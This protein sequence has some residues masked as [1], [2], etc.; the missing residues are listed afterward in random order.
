M[1]PAGFEPP[2]HLDPAPIIRRDQRSVPK[3]DLGGSQ[4]VIGKLQHDAAHVLVG[5]EVA[6]RELKVV[7]STP[8]VVK[9]GVATPAR[10]E[11]ILASLRHL[12]FWAYRHRSTLDDRFPAVA[13]SGGV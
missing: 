11:A 6:A 1:S 12:R 10:E 2:I 8:H 3:S 4:H 5:E 13:G 9:E 7:Q